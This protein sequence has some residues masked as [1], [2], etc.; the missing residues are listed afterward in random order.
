VEV[1]QKINP[2]FV[3]LLIY[4]LCWTFDSKRKYLQKQACEFYTAFRN[5]LSQTEVCSS[6]FN[7]GNIFKKTYIVFLLMC[8]I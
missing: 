3:L 4:N 5:I 2:C 6:E 1:K 8:F 7:T